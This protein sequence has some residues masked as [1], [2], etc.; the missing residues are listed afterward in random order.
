[1]QKKLSTKA[2]ILIVVGA[3][4]AAALLGAA[5][6]L[7]VIGN[8]SRIYPNVYASGVNL[9]GLTR[10]QAVEA[11]NQSIAE[12]Y[13]SETLTVE[14]PDRTLDFSPE[15]VKAN[16]DAESV[17]DDAWQFGR[18]GS[19]FNRV[20]AYLKAR[21]AKTAYTAN[22][23]IS[24]DEDAIRAHIQETADAVYKEMVESKAELH[25]DEDYIEVTIGT[26]GVSLDVDSL[27][28]AVVT[29]VQEQNFEPI[30]FGYT[31]SAYPALDLSKIYNEVHNDVADAY[32]DAEKHEIVEE[33]IGY[34]FDLAAANQ[35]IAMAKDGD[36]L[37]I[38]MEEVEPKETK[39]HLEEI[40]FADVLG[41]C[42]T[43]G[44]GGYNRA[45]NI[46]K[47]CEAIDGTVLA[48]GEVF[49]Y[50]KTTGERTAEKG[51]LQAGA[52][53]QGKSVSEY[54]GGVCQV[55]STIYYA[56]LM[57]N[58]EITVRS[59][60]MYTVSYVPM[61]MDATVNWG[62]QDFQFKNNTEYPV[63]IECKV[64]NGQCKVRLLG[65]KTDDTSVEMTYEILNTIPYTTT[66]T[67]NP[68]EVNNV[69][70]TGYYV[71]TYRHILDKD[72]NEI[73]KKL[74]AYSYYMK[75]DI[76]VLQSDLDEEINNRLDE[77]QEPDN[78]EG[79]TP[80]ESEGS[81]EES[82]SE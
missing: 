42:E 13:G 41:S 1:M 76:V 32:Y 2:I 43:G 7:L 81:P 58:L 59:E 35:R 46:T 26:T 34:G 73:S 72:G 8:T 10:E 66:V 62:T 29:A 31:E 47:A 80:P 11:L 82:S 3:I 20:G 75:S 71:V 57:A 28:E 67:T 48:P 45:N 63:R 70:R 5:I 18:H 40:Y 69:G 9:G 78:P 56:C 23:G 44:L 53:V 21:S 74:E 60:H 52:Y 54:G 4:L 15:L 39:A 24:V 79:E 55:S 19:I 14:L 61:G 68:S 30:T 51:Y 37:R 6:F 17:V 38:D 64:E 50:N 36:V 16:V 27:T 25:R 33:Q 12:N 49:S 77:E 22:A 65:T